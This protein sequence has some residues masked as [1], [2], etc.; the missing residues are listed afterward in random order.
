MGWLGDGSHRG[1][2]CQ[3]WTAVGLPPRY[4]RYQATTP[5]G[6]C[7]SMASLPGCEC[8]MKQMPKIS[9]IASPM[10][11][12]RRPP[13]RPR[14]MWM[15][16]IQQDLKLSN[17]SV[18]EAINEAQNHPLWRE[19][20]TFGDTHSFRFMPEITECHTLNTL[21]ACQLVQQISML[22]LILCQHISHQTTKNQRI[23][24]GSKECHSWLGWAWFKVCAN[25]I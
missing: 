4:P 23:I 22:K 5:F 10:E 8:Q 20:S 25:T 21:G 19:M 2:G 17:L 7:A 18:N 15:M 6:Y 12:W 1:Q 24:C 11:N 3:A 9:L 14:T 16:S 13:G